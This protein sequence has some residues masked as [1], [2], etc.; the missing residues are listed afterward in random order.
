MGRYLHLLEQGYPIRSILAITFT[1]KAA[2]EMRSRIRNALSP[3]RSFIHSSFILLILTSARI[4]TIHC[5]CAELLRAHPA[6]AGLDPAFEV[7][8]EGLPP[9]CK[10]KRS[11][12]RWHGLRQMN[13]PPR[14]LAFSKKTNCGKFSTR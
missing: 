3:I 4:G 1:E 2:R 6:E 12:P 8:E 11:S 10:P 13:S 7:L 5:L 14:C 9:P